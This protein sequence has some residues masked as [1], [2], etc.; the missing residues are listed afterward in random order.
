M[1]SIKIISDS[2]CDLDEKLL[3][4]YDIKTIPLMITMGAET[5]KDGVE[6]TPEEI[7]A[8]SDKTGET[9]K[10]AAPAVGD[11]E[12]FLRP[13]AEN[14]D[15]TIFFGISEDMSATCNVLR[16]A[17]ENIGYKKLH[18]IN[19]KSLSTGIGLQAI[20]A[21]ILAGEGHSA[22]EILKDNE[23]I[24]N[25]VRASFIVDTLKFLHRGGRCSSVAALIAN[26]L[27]LK[28]EIQ[29]SDGKMGVARKYRGNLKSVILKYVQ[30]KFSQLVNADPSRIFITHSGCPKE[31]ID[32]VK[33]YLKGLGIFK[34]ILET[35]AGSVI[36]SHCGP[37]TLGILWISN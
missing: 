8:W 17:A 14:D 26:T 2:T 5:L 33:E 3:M 23:N 15:E 30:D 7:F 19:S 36:S 27:R 20:R 6:V 31:I 9:P 13:Y 29:V 24:N 10:T 1:S 28:P 34:E 12:D 18:V 32:A 21:A 35:R 16:L 4:Q 11:A 22:M 25:K 37:N